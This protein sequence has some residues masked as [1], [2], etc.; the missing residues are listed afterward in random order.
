MHDTPACINWVRLHIT[1]L[2][3]YNQDG[4]KSAQYS[5]ESSED[6]VA[7]KNF[8]AWLQLLLG[9]LIILALLWFYWPVLGSL[10]YSLTT[11]EDYSFG[12]LLPFV[13]AYIVYLKWPKLRRQVWQPSWTGLLIIAL[14][15]VIYMLGDLA[16]AF[17]FPP[18]SFLVVVTG[19]LW[20]LGGWRVVR[21]LS[22]PLV[23]LFFMIPLPA[24]VMKTMTI[25]L[26]LISSQLAAGMLQ[27]IGIPVARQGNILDLGV[28]QLQ[29]ENACS[30]LRYILSL[31]AL[32]L[33]FCYFYQRRLWKAVT[34]L[35]FLVP[36]AIL[37]NAIRVAAMGRFPAIMEGFWHS[38]TGWLIFL[39]CL[40][41]MGLLNWLLNYLEPHLT[42]DTEAEAPPS[43]PPSQAVFKGSYTPYLVVTLAVVLVAGQM[44][45]R[46]S[47]A[48]PVPLLQSL[49]KFPLNFGPYQGRRS[50]LDQSM[51]KAV[52]ADAYFEAQY[53][54]P[55]HEPV[56]LW[57]AYFESQSK[58]VEG[59]IHSPLICLTGGGWTILE[60]KIVAVGPNLPVRYLLME[61]RD[62]REVVY[63]WYLQQGNWVASEYSSRLFMGWNGLMR[64]RNDGAIV[65]LITP[66]G[67]NAA[68]AR[69]RL[70]S[71]VRSLV[72]VLPQFMSK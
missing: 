69:A 42:S 71:F 27:G 45:L 50:Y 35:I 23:L 67:P 41:F 16:A 46:L 66:A 30:G 33:I 2:T 5:P 8:S 36:A 9:T 15:F 1:C 47:N 10:A 68:Q 64:H 57:I 32:G 51:A 59:R 3:L 22:F 56:S 24:M 54:N 14:G 43:A 44:A 34:L 17:Y 60:S 18:F 29:V 37:A 6:M 72:P 13:S 70:D 40:G 28:R 20:L 52:G 55:G 19:L 31:S 39:F 62:S 4:F 21:G 61:Q 26:Q 53:A 38:F 58:K 11:S 25:P 65:R 48:P 63:Y 12:L 7:K 49:D